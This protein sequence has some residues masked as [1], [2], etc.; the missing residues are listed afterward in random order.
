MSSGTIKKSCQIFP[1][2]QKERKKWW[3]NDYREEGEG[4]E[5]L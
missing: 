4:R 5:D 2:R 3:W 1:G